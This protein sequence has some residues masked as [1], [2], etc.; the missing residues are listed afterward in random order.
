MSKK[1]AKVDLSKVN[2][3]RLQE[4][5]KNRPHLFI[6]VDEIFPN[7]WNKNR[8]G[9]QYYMALKANMANESI[10]FTIPILVREH[11]EGN[12]YQ[13]IDG[14]HRWKASKD[15]G[16]KEIPCIVMPN[17]SDT[18]LKFLMI[19]SNAIHGTTSDADQKAVLQDIELQKE[20]EDWLKEV[21]VWAYT[22]TDEPEDNSSKYELP[23]DANDVDKY[24]T[25]PVTLYLTQEQM[26]KFKKIIGQLRF[27]RGTTQ[28]DAV[29]ECIEHFEETT[30]FGEIEKEPE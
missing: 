24:D 17:V 30:G 12:G 3:E 23:P 13:I 20:T 11:P 21:D 14:E 5:V 26:I 27:C 15:V 7:P 22:V 16:L 1:N 18:L 8:M 4:V 28:E 2:R 10:G 19:E 6:S 29:L 9:S 25:Q